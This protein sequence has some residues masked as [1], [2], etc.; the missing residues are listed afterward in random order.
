MRPKLTAAIILIPLLCSCAAF[1]AP[2]AD[3]SSFDRFIPVNHYSQKDDTFCGLAA[4][5]MIADFYGQALDARYHGLLEKEA[6][7]T[8]GIQAA[9]L[10]ACLEASGFDVAVF[11]GTLDREL[12]GIYRNLDLKRPLIALISE[13]PGENGHYVIINGYKGSGILAV[14]N[15]DGGQ[16]TA[17]IPWFSPLWKTSGYLIIL[18]LPKK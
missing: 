8:K 6:K 3:F 7:L 15:P 4:I 18:A 10:K 16:T 11:P 12:P 2:A 1:R 17:G 9:S 14:M 13:K 5:Q